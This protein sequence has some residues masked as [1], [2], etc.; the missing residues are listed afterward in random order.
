MR[1]RRLRSRA[2]AIAVAFTATVA[3]TGAS[4]QAPLIAT[5]D[6]GPKKQ[7]KKRSAKFFFSSDDPA[8]TFE[9]RLDG[10][11]FA[12]C[13]SPLELRGLVRGRHEFEVRAIAP[14]GAVSEP[15]VQKWK[16]VKKGGS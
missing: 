6:D 10:P 13:L 5:I 3:A 2:T 11:P 7:T 4:A 16:I 9:C 14:T 12:A 8:A 15:A 1:E